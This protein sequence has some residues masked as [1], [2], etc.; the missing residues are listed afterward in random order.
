MTKALRINCPACGSSYLLDETAMQKRDWPEKPGGWL[1]GI[2]CPV[3]DVF[4]LS[5]RMTPE[6]ETLRIGM[7]G[8]LAAYHRQRSNRLWNVYQRALNRY[9]AAFDAVQAEGKVGEMIG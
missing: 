9:Q 2:A 5:C 4:H 1:V 6:L 7:R 3:C 8:A